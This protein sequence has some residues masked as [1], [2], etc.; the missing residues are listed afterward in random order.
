MPLRVNNLRKLS[1][2]ANIGRI[3]KSFLSNQD[4]NMLE[5]LITKNLAQA[6]NHPPESKDI[7]A[8]IN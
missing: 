3:Y 6:V 8:T 4:L 5:F 2:L 7:L 1:S